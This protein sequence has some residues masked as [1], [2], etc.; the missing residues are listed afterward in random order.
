M[1]S[2]IFGKKVKEKVPYNVGKA[3]IK[4]ISKNKKTYYIPVEGFLE[5]ECI[6]RERM[7]FVYFAKTVEDIFNNFIEES[8]S[9]LVKI[10]EDFGLGPTEIK[11]IKLVE[12]EDH[13]VYKT[14]TKRIKN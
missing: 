11:S 10:S 12:R 3:K 1:L 14:I 7:R 8:K 5:S 9:G 6:S 4:I 2:L 13:F